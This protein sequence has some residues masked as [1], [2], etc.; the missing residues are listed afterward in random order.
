MDR[1][2]EKLAEIEEQ[3]QEATAA[4]ARAN[5]NA[6]IQ[7]E[8]TT[9]AVFRLKGAQELFVLRSLLMLTDHYR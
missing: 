7:K 5:Y 2:N 4:I 3:K 6:H 9:S 1:L 8:S